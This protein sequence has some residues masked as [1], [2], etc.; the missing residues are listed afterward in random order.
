MRRFFLLA[1]AAVSACGSVPAPVSPDKAGGDLSVFAAASLT[2]AF[3]AAGT[4]FKA[5]HPGS[6][7]TF[8]FAGTPTLLT[9]LLQGAGAD[10]FASADQ[11]NM[12]KAVDAKLVAGAPRVFATNKL[13]IVVGAG[14]PKHISGLADLARADVLYI[15]EAPDVPAAKYAAQALAAAGVKPAPRSL[16]AD[17][18]GVVSKVA[19]GEADAGIVYVTDVRAARGRVSGVAIPDAQNPRAGYLVAEV[20]AAHN[21]Y[22]ARAFIDYLLSAGGQQVLQGFGFTPP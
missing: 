11:P 10:V 21:P 8:N 12:Q 9:Q 16:E 22:A 15:T 17:V 20:R 13:E 3:K 1:L 4:G 5:A 6:N 19:L 2:E 18:K 7:P 14:N